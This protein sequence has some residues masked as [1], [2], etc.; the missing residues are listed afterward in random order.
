MPIQVELT[1]LVRRQIASWGLPDSLLVE[2]YLRLQRDL[3][4]NPAQVLIR[5]EQPFDGM[6][7]GYSII[8]PGN[9]LRE[10]LFLFQVLYSQN[11]ERLLVVRGGC[12]W[13]EGF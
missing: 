7:Y 11:E 9:R 5:T 6:C 13:R 2:T 10:Y 12:Q 4:Q 3:S 1:P 8:D